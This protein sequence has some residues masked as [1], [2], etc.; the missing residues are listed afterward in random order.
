MKRFSFIG[1][2]SY[3]LTI[4]LF[5]VHSLTGCDNKYVNV[6]KVDA[7]ISQSI[8][9]PN[10]PY[11]DKTRDLKRQPAEILSFFELKPGMH[12]AEILAGGGYYTEL[13]S[14]IIGDDGKV[15]MHN[16]RQYYEFQTDKSVNERLK[17]NR[18]PNVALWNQELESLQ[19]PEDSIDAVFL[20]LVLHDFYWMSETPDLIFEQIHSAI[21]PDGYLAVVDHSAEFGT[22]TKHASDLNGLHRI[23]KDFVIEKLTSIG[24]D[25]VAESDVL[26][27]PQDNKTLPFFA[28]EMKGQATDRFVLRFKKRLISKEPINRD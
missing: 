1:I 28:E 2:F 9:H 3:A 17:E 18:L 27:N 24:F 14:R 11:A 20:M 5:A 13:I 22:G 4:F 12:V 21:K 19:L 26:S 6:S 15:F 16:N 23:E 7:P 8:N 10:R 25:L